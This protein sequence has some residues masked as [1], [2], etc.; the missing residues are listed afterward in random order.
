MA[1]AKSIPEETQPGESLPDLRERIFSAKAA[2][3]RY[4]VKAPIPEKLRILEEMRDT[5]RALNA[6]REQNKARVRA[7]VSSRRTKS[8]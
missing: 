1:V 4:L 3:R 5:T 2:R 6:V 8:A 7:A